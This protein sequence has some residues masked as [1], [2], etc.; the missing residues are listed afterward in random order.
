[1][2]VITDTGP[3]LGWIVILVPVFDW[4]L[5]PRLRRL[6]GFVGVTALGSAL[7]NNTIKLVVGRARPHVADPVATAIGKSF[8]SGHTEAALVGYG[9]LLL[10]DRARRALPVRRLRRSAHRRRV[11]ARDDG[12]L[13]GVAPRP[14]RPLVDDSAP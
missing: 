2:R 1:M 3:S 6:A 13:R 11:D 9:I 4:L 7:L 10:P 14:G 8:P 5:Y 12:R